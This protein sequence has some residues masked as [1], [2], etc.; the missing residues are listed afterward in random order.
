MK[1]VRLPLAEQHGV[2]GAA[3]IVGAE[4]VLLQV[5]DV[6]PAVKDGKIDGIVTNWG[7]PLQGFNDFMKLHIETQFYTSAFFIVMNK[8]EIRRPAGRRARRD[9]RDL[10]RRL[11]GEVRS[12]LGQMGQAG[13]RRRQCAGP[14]GD[15]AGCGAHGRA[16][17]RRS[18]R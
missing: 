3:S 8:R 17:A 2:G 15:R 13:A 7:N 10:G 5:N 9:R 14:R 4:P 16:G 1:G 18:S 6:M 12:L 11:G